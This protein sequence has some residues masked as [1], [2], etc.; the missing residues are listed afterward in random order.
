MRPEMPSRD[1]PLRSRTALFGLAV[2]LCGVTTSACTGAGES[3]APP[4]SVSGR[5]ADIADR[6]WD[7]Y[8]E[9]HPL[10]ATYL[11]EKGQDDR[12]E[13]ITPQGRQARSDM[14]GRFVDELASIDP[15]QLGH[16]DRLTYLALKQALEGELTR[17]GCEPAV[18]VVDHR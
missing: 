7:F 5:I 18:W 4:A 15:G 3:S 16:R 11:G 8:L 1:P 6:Y 13:D 9:W 2:V 12:L 14:A 17:Q 10:E